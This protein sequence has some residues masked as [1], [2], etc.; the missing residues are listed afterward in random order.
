M[1]VN[2]ELFNADGSMNTPTAAEVERKLA[3][4]TALKHTYVNKLR[5]R[6]ISGVLAELVS[7]DRLAYLY[8]DLEQLQK[9]GV[10]HAR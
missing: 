1:R 3:I 2:F 4:V 5:L 9:E 8:D 7:P 6:R 10:T